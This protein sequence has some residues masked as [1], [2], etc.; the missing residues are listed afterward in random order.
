[1]TLAGLLL[2]ATLAT[3]LAMVGLCLLPAFRRRVFGLLALAPLPGVVTALLAPGGSL[4]LA[5]APFRLVLALDGPGAMLLGGAALLWTAAGLYARTYM[6]E[7]AERAGFAIWW[8][9]TLAGSLGVF[10]VADMTS[11]YLMFSLVSLS[12]YGLVMHENSARAERAGFF[13]V[14]LALLGEACLLFAFVLLATA[15]PAGNQLIADAVATL[16]ASPWRDATL[17]LLILGFGLKMG[18]APLH[19]WMPL[20]HPVAPMPASAVLSGIVVKA[21]VIGLIRFLP[22]GTPLAEWGGALMVLGLGTAYYGVAFGITQRHPKTVLAYSTVSQMGLVAAIA[23][24]GLAIGDAGVADLVAYYAL[25]HMLVKGA[26][27]LGVGV[28]AATGV[29][30]RGPV[31]ALMAVMA[32]SLAGLP[33]TSG[34]LAK[35]AAK[36]PFGDGLAAMLAALSAAG[37][38]L[39]MLHFLRLVSSASK[40]APGAAAPAGMVLPFAGTALASLVAGWALLG[41]ATGYTAADVLSLTALRDA[42]WP[43]L[44][45]MVLALALARFGN[46]LPA[47]PEGDV[48]VLAERAAPMVRALGAGIERLDAVLRRW[49]VAG[50]SLVALVLA[51]G[52]ALGLAP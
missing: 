10:V 12:A 47:V 14:T 37:S 5:P 2:V 46:R 22:F 48:V 11:F 41:P 39:L 17:V 35:Y 3:P 30:R 42:S 7:E 1:M 9:L 26:L 32:L 8:L 33:F 44:L 43:I 4:L 40:A 6:R 27:F 49:P 45:G 21:G 28:V 16:D 18:L 23:G 36:A 20:A 25:H 31:L 52:A 15:G 24:T 51:L 13:Y 29:R 34:A 38:A 19:V 50:V